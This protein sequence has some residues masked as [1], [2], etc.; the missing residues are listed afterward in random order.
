MNQVKYLG[1][2]SL[3]ILFFAFAALI[4]EK[5]SSTESRSAKP[6]TVDF[7]Q[8]NAKPVTINSEGKKIFQ[9][10]CQTCHALDKT[11]TGPALRGVENR[12]PWTD[13]KNLMMW[14]KNPATT[15]NKFQYT[16]DLVEQFGGQIMPSF[17]HLTD[18]QIENIFDYITNSPVQ[19]F[20]AI[21]VN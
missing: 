11:I 4:F 20:M 3:L 1:Y 17:S 15:I 2:A 7:L 21:A 6:M 10:N 14:I 9:N 13:R 18:K 16:K 12:G 5:I 19:G 8:P